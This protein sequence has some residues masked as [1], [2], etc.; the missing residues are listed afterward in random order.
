MLKHVN[1]KELEKKFL[2][3]QAELIILRCRFIREASASLKEAMVEFES[4]RCEDGGL[5]EHATWMLGLTKHLEDT[6]C[7]EGISEFMNAFE[8]L[9]YGEWAQYS[10]QWWSLGLSIESVE[11]QLKELHKQLSIAKQNNQM[12]RAFK[13]AVGF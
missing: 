1:V 7:N 11:E 10:H 13:K 4:Y 9:E 5:T 3:L 6:L 8:S 2:M 12:E